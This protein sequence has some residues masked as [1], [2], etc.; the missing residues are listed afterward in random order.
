[1]AETILKLKQGGT[2]VQTASALTGILDNLVGDSGSG[3]TKGLVPAPSAGDAAAN[4]FLKA[5][6]TWTAPA[7]SGDVVGPASA[8]DNAIV[9]YNGTTGKLIKDSATTLSAKQDQDNLLDAISTLAGN[10]I[11]VRQTANTAETR[12][13]V[14]GSSKITVSNGD[15]VS[16]NPSIDLG[17]VTTADVSASTDK[18]YVTDAQATVIGNTSGINT[19]DQDLSG[20]M[21][22]AN[23][24]SDLT[25][26]TTAR[27]NLGVEIGVD[28]QAYDLVLEEVASQTIITESTTSRTFALTDANDYIRCT[29]ASATTLTIPANSTVAFP[30]GTQIDVFQAGAG[31]VSFAAAG[32]VTIN[33]AEGLKIAAQYKAASLKKVATDEWDL[34]GALAA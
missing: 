12:S 20:L 13:I 10:G 17:T 33:K 19:G 7:G 31:Q 34:I 1:M 5:D 23:N 6:G 16:G 26:T 25:N 29:N 15:G 18:N 30:I 14:A 21:V 3:G 27:S 28:V 11:I 8:T 24:L 9:L 2:G 32:G 4:K 22:K